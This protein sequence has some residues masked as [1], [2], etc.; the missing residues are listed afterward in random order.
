[1][2]EIE[3]PEIRITKNP[4]FKMIYA[5]GVFGGLTPIEGRITFYVDRLFPRIIN[6][7]GAMATEYL[8]RELQ[9]EVKMSPGH[10]ISIYQWMKGHIERMEKQGVIQ[11]EIKKEEEES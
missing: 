9:V 3:V 4:D 11:K 2:S 5:N 1:M 8:E 10:F 6:E 7:L